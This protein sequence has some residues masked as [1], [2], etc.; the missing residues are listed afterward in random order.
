[1]SFFS[2]SVRN[3]SEISFCRPPFDSVV[4]EYFFV[5]FFQLASELSASSAFFAASTSFLFSFTTTR[6]SRDGFFVYWVAFSAS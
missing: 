1:M 2:G 6:T 3:S 5:T 4:G